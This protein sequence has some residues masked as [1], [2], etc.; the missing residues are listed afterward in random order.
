LTGLSAAITVHLQ[1]KSI[2]KDALI[3]LP[4]ANSE[5]T[6]YTGPL[7]FGSPL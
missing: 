2:L 1:E 5:N 4:M 3:N 6:I 7:Y